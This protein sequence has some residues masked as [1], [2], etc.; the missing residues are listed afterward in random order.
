MDLAVAGSEQITGVLAADG[1][2]VPFALDRA[3]FDAKAKPCPQSID[4]K[5][6]KS[7]TAHYTLALQRDALKPADQFPQ[8]HGFGVV[9]VKPDGTVRFTGSL[10]D[11][12]ALTQSAVISRTGTW[13]FHALLYGKRGVI[14]GDLTFRDIAQVS[15]LDGTL[16]WIKP[17]LTG[18][19]I[20]YPAGFATQTSV[21]GS[22]YDKSVPVP[23][24]T[25]SFGEG[26]LGLVP[27]QVPVTNTLGS[28]TASPSV[29]GFRG[30]F[31]QS[32]GLF[33]G[34]L[35]T[36]A[37]AKAHKFQ[38]ALFQKTQRGYGWFIGAPFPAGGGLPTGFVEFTGL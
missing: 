19:T 24:G 27:A 20:T 38:G 28:W 8:G 17:A 14:T 35:P 32:T 16:D 2:S 25:L 33:T 10:G 22:R 21:I 23:D 4:P 31:A 34:N 36:A 3:V 18:A 26:N 7:R 12:T 30:Q 11:G 13:P 1:N 6:G 15:D 9:T 37:S 5:T 29:T